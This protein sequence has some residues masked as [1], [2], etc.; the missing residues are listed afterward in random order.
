MKKFITL[1]VSLVLILSLSSCAAPPETSSSAPVTESHSVVQTTPA[2][3]TTTP[4]VTTTAPITTKPEP[5]VYDESGSGDTVLQ[6]ITIKSAYNVLTFTHSGSSN[7]IVKGHREDGSYELLV[8]TIGPYQGTVLLDDAAAFM[9]EIKADGNWTVHDETI[10]G[11]TATSFSGSGDFVTTVTQPGTKIF[12][13]THDGSSNFIVRQHSDVGTELLVNEI[14]AY[15]GQVV[16]RISASEPC[17]F[18]II[19]DG[20]WTIKPVS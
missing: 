6:N 20:N 4:P 1:V 18:E 10:H 13:F 8:N 15:S 5:I 7:F 3:V 11:D 12:E 16:S 2:P 14:G 9:L 17:L 19:A